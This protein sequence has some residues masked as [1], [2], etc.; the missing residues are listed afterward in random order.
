MSEATQ[1]VTAPTAAPSSTDRIFEAFE[2][3]ETSGTVFA[4]CSACGN[5]E[6]VEP[7]GECD[8]SNC[9]NHVQSP[10]LEAGMI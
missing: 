10:L 3:M 1:A 7:D 5:E 2:Q 8:C 6:M 9:G 4:Y